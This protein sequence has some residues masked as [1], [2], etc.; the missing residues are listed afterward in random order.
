MSEETNKEA[1]FIGNAISKAHEAGSNLIEGAS[2]GA[3]G[4]L[5]GAG[6]EGRAAQNER[7]GDL[8]KNLTTGGLAIGGGAGALVALVNYLKTLKQEDELEDESRL[9]DDTLYIPEIKKGASEEQQKEAVNRWLAPGLGVTGGILGAAGSY[10][11]VQ[12]VYNHL[13]KQ[14]HQK[15]LDEAQGEALAAADMEVEKSAKMGFYDLVTAF[16]V[17]V[18]LL[19]AMASGGVAYAALNKTFPTVKRPKSKYPKRIRQVSSSGEVSDYEDEEDALK[20]ASVIAAENDCQDSAHEFL[21]LVVD[22]M[23]IEKKA[24]ICL[25][26]DLINRVAKDGSVAPLAEL[27]KQG[28]LE[29]VIEAIKG[30]SDEPVDLANKSLAAAVL[31]KSARLAPVVRS[32]ASAEYQDMAPHVYD[33]AVSMGEE[34][35]DKFAGIAPLMNFAYFRPQILEKSAAVNPLLQELQ[36]LTQAGGLASPDMEEALTSDATGGLAEE[37]EGEEEDTGDPLASPTMETSEQDPVD[38]FLEAGGAESPILEPDVEIEEDD[39]ERAAPLGA[40][41]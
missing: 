23:G 39:L 11:L 28:G 4:I 18:P 31:C 5:T 27:Q 3:A 9:N 10:A 25:T 12:A 36:Q 30:A 32:I 1:A 16:P 17:A 29:A 38:N 8:V 20:S 24:E 14:R 6:G 2:R 33:L 41:L 21:M 34:K 22:Q 26:S 19:A 7:G 15:M 13:K 40:I 35:M 37:A